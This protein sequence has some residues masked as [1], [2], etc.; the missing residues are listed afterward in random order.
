MKRKV[1]PAERLLAGLVALLLLPL[2]FLVALSIL[3]TDG[4]PVFFVQERVGQGGR[5]FPLIKFRSM[6][7]LR[8]G[9]SR[10][11]LTVPTDPTITRVGKWLRRS[12]VDEWPQLLNIIRGE[13][14][15]VGPRPELACYVAYYRP[16]ERMVLE[17]PPGLTDPASIAFRH[18]GRILAR[19]PDPEKTYIKHLMPRKIRMNLRYARLRTPVSDCCVVVATVRR[20]LCG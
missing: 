11:G 10:S 20:L 5:S 3:V 8:A 9:Q 12:R 16:E 6:T 14:S 7:R 2:G 1:A 19:S 18:E 4:P 15:W 13:M 17:S